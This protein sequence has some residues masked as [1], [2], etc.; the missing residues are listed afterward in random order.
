MQRISLARAVKF[1]C[2]KI[3]FTIRTA[4]GGQAQ[5]NRTPVKTKRNLIR[6]WLTGVVLLHVMTIGAQTVTRI[7][8]G[9][10][11][12]L[13]LKSNGSL[14]ATGWNLYGQLGNGTYAT[15][16]PYGTNLPVQ[17]VASNVTAIAVGGGHSLFLKSNG[18]L[19]AVGWN[20]Y[21]QLGDGTTDNGNFETNQ[22]EQIV[23]SNV[24]VIAAGL[25]H[26]LFLKSN[27][28]LWA[29][30]DNSY[31][32]LGDNT[33]DNG[34]FETNRPEQIVASGV[35]AISAGYRH[36]LFLKNDGS[37]WA[38]GNNA[39]GQLGTGTYNNTNQPVQI[40]ASNVT[41]IAA[42]DQHS[43]FLMSN[44]SLWAM[45]NNQA[46]QLGD[47]TV[48]TTNSPDLIVASNVTAMAAGSAHSL[49]LMSNGSLWV[50]GNNHYGQLGDGSYNNTN[51]PVQ[52]MASGVTAIAAGY[53][54]SLFIKSDGSLWGMGDNLNGQLGDST[55]ISTNL[56]V[57]TQ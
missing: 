9:F 20:A 4:A 23:A 31:G 32:Q 28:S 17:I 13:F 7:T 6:I 40:V 30:G 18:S 41:A 48:G 52:I 24:T 14:W 1:V 12:S 46:G 45:G 27:G 34:N 50:M 29:M 2:V 25:N 39:Y 38:M 49:V 5:T 22:P 16:Y 3:R 43:L 35:A 10:Y 53:G 54:H 26:S 15:A 19:W 42:G 51:R 47:P 21:G 36:S 11:H 55:Y 37:L 44:G 33:T 57:Q 56:P 8:A